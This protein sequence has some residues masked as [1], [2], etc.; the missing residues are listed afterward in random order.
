MTFL[1]SM[2]G[3]LI[4]VVLNL[5]LI[6]TMEA[7]GAAI[8]TLVSYFAVFVIRSVNARRYVPFSLSL[9]RMTVSFLVLIAQT[10]S[11]LY[12]DAYVIWTQVGAF[13]IIA[14]INLVPFVQGTKEL[15]ESRRKK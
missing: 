8:A 1:T 14:L 12:L 9:P 5:L 2:S 7:Q 13:L 15:L 6:P 4:N 3:A 10:L 11:M